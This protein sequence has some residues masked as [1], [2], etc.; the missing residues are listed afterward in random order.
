MPKLVN[1][2][3]LAEVKSQLSQ[4]IFAALQKSP[5]ASV[6]LL[7]DGNSPVDEFDALHLNQLAS[8]LPKVQLQEIRRPDLLDEPD[9]WLTLLLLRTHTDNGYPDEA[10][11]DLSIENALQRAGSIN[12]AY[13]CGWLISD[14][15][16]KQIATH[17]SK[18]CILFD[19]HRGQ[20]RVLPYFEPYRLALLHAMLSP[21]KINPLIKK[22]NDWHYID[23]LGNLQR[24]SFTATD[25]TSEE[26]TYIPLAVWQAQA[27]VHDGRMVLMALYKS[28]HVIPLKPEKAI[29]LVLQDA[30]ALG[31]SDI[32]DLIFFALN[33]F[34]LSKGWMQHPAA[35]QAIT[36]A[37]TATAS[38]VDE[39]NK[40]DESVVQEIADYAR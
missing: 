38:L 21:V 25:P 27:R 26:N 33:S 37:A 30:A 13:V 29:D 40:L 9:C 36:N 23:G 24:V 19:S 8:R 16:A 5:D 20:Q 2:T 7:L 4:E 39:F 12:G 32:E 17:L 22:I 3:Q 28:G 34:S 14:A 6:Y 10:I 31:L 18:A 15:S 1:A 11:F 35:K